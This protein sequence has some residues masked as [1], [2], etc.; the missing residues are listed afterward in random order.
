MPIYWAYQ[1]KVCIRYVYLD[2]T[3]VNAELIRQGFAYAYTT[4]SFSK[5]AEFKA[6]ESDAKSRLRGLWSPEACPTKVDEESE[7]LSASYYVTN[8]KTN[9]QKD[10][11]W[12]RERLISEMLKKFKLSQQEIAGLVYKL[13]P[14]I[15]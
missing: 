1:I 15:K 5:I 9:Y 4:Y 14:D 12:F 8:Q 3:L 13:L 6:L 7:K 10:H 2:S 11:R